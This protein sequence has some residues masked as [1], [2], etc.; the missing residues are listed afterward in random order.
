MRRSVA[1]GG[2]RRHCRRPILRGRVGGGGVARLLAEQG[3]KIIAVDVMPQKLEW[4][5]RF[6]ATHVDVAETHAAL[7]RAYRRDGRLDGLGD[8]PPSAELLAEPADHE[9]RVVDREREPEHR[10][11]V[12]DVDREL[13]RLG[14]EVDPGERRRDRQPRHEQG[15]AGDRFYVIAEGAASVEID[16]APR[17]LGGRRR[18][19]QLQQRGV[20]L[21]RL[22]GRVFDD[23]ARRVSQEVERCAGADRLRTRPHRIRHGVAG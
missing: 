11:H 1:G 4:A 9:Q 5:R 23:Q 8:G 17:T 13:G 2:F 14:D 20:H 12:L 15:Q 18:V 3:G 19:Q 10:R 6:G 22:E 7:S 16:G 21:A